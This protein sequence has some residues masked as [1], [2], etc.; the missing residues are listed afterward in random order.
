LRA[1]EIRC[2]SLTRSKSIN[3]QFERRIV[4][5]DRRNLSEGQVQEVRF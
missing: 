3:R 1:R 4:D 5:V 2:L